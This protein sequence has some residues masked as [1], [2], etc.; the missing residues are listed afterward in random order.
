MVHWSRAAYRGWHHGGRIAALLL[1]LVG[2]SGCAALSD[3]VQ[4][5]AAPPLP[6]TSG[7]QLPAHAA[8][9]EARTPAPVTIIGPSLRPPAQATRTPMVSVIA[10]RSAALPFNIII[11]DRGNN[12]I[13]EVTPDKQIVWSYHFDTLRLGLGADDAF[14]TPGN[15]TI[16]ANL[17]ENQ[18]IV[19]I[20]IDK[21]TTQIVWQY[22]VTGHPGHGDGELNIPY[23]L[24]WRH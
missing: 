4:G 1:A 13:I 15:Q 3:P 2:V 24:D 17:E 8:S 18:M 7:A 11:A 22:G 16:I 19:E 6:S 14:F 20:A 10:G 5:R 9:A 23:G 21:T 12:R